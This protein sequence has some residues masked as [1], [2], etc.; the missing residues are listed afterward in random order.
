M[1]T[2]AGGG[3]IGKMEIR[4]AQV[5]DAPGIAVV[6]V[7]SWQEAYRGLLPQGF[8]DGLNP[9]QR[10]GFWERILAAG[11]ERSGV[12]VADDGE[13]LL[14]F[15]CF[16]PARD[17]DAGPGRTGEI[18]AIY[19]LPDVWGKGWGRQLMAATVTGMTG[20]GFRQAVLWVLDTNE[21][22]RRFYQAAGWSVDGAVK[23]DTIGGAV[24]TEVRYRRSLR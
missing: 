6:H 5:G 17:E 1:P 9:V 8:L 10:A 20:A 2:S 4:P 24:V 22:A 3:T 15:A 23:A 16:G 14:G 11:E 13:G 12:V 7:R 19:L 21:R 18:M